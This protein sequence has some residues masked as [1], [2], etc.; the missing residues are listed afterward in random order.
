[1]TDVI[2]HVPDISKMFAE[3]N[4]VLKKGGKVCIVTQ[5]HHQIEKRPIVQFF[6]G[7]ATVDKERYPDINE[8]I[9]T[10]EE[11]YLRF[12][13]N[14][15]L[16]ENAEIELD[17]EY[18]DLAKKKGHSMLH[19]ISDKEYREGLKRLETELRHGS[20]RSKL[21]GVTLVWFIKE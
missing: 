11:Q 2:H 18:L 17:L 8:I 15:I 16:N 5:S 4:R 19:L 12:M 6:P 3:I 1:M 21:S 14:V 20:I 13:K 9:V 7:T 10:A